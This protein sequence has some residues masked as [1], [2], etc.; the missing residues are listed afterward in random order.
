MSRP[1]LNDVTGRHPARR[2]LANRVERMLT[3]TPTVRGAASVIVT[4][5]TTVVVAGAILI[6]LLDQRDFPSIW[7]ALWWSVQ[8]ATTV[9]YGDVTPHE[10][11]GR[12]VATFVMLQGIAI[13]AV[14]TAS[15]TSVFVARAQRLM[16]PPDRDQQ[17]RELM[18][19]LDELDRRLDAMGGGGSPSS[20]D[21]RTAERRFNR[22][23]ES[24]QE[25]AS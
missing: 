1:A 11:V 24:G 17:W 19:R 15:I 2:L 21:V 10:V 6:R 20:N 23:Q 4:A 7:L 13:L 16:A 25:D 14:V 8:T 18:R 5:S 22:R 3:G 9:G 12:V